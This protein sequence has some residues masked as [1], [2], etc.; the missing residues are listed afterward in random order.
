M[1]SNTLKDDLTVPGTTVLLDAAT[2]GGEATSADSITL[3]PTPSDD[4]SDPLNWT[5]RRKWLCCACMVL[6]VTAMCFNVGC[7]YPIYGPLPFGILMMGL[8]P[9]YKAHW[10][11]FVMGEFVLTIAGPIATLLSITYAF[12]AFHSIHPKEKQSAPYLLS[13]ILVGMI[14]TFCFN[15]C[16][17]PW[18]FDWGFRNWAISAV[19]IG[20]A[21]NCSA[22]LMIYY[23]KRLRKSG[24]SYYEKIIN[25]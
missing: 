21:V 7:L 9:Y 22:F 1:T 25:I 10:M 20:T 2:G 5:T 24:V 19:F 3:V 16:V 14:F 15:Y 13:L 12:D 18:A 23:G 11:V 4:P 17:T 6:Y 8:G